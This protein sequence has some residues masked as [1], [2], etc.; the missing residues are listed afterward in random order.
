MTVGKPLLSVPGAVHHTH[1]AFADFFDN[2]VVAEP[3]ANLAGRTH[4]R[5][6]S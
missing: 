5:R 1:S 4:P 2:L 3:Q 6:A